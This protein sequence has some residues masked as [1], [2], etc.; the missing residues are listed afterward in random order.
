MGFLR[1]YV[2][3]K[4]TEREEKKRLH[5]EQ[6]EKFRREIIKT[7]ELLD[8]FT[9][10]QLNKFCRDM[11]GKSPE[12]EIRA[13]FEAEAEE[14][15]KRSIL[16]KGLHKIMS[17]KTE[18]A[19]RKTYYQF[20]EKCLREEQIKVS[21]IKDYAVKEKIV[22]PSYFGDESK[23]K[24]EFERLMNSIEDDFKPERIKEEKE[25]QAQ[26]VVFLKAKFA[27]MKVERE[28]QT[29]RGNE[30]D[31]LVENNYVFE[32]KVPKVRNDL[33]A[34]S[35]QVEEYLEEYPNLCVVIADVS[36][37]EK[38]NEDE[39]IDSNLTQ[40]IKEYADRYKMKYG[41]KTLIFQIQKRK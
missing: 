22:A 30:L 19:D 3:K 26:L 40:N 4:R 16:S 12:E 7:Y 15:A 36:K 25:F 1:N 38:I 14:D 18:T 24:K 35:A 41:V 5:E 34:L 6:L 28:Q 27:E 23:E 39:E 9:I 29:K 11:I 17:N 13:E 20:I 37:A 31:I 21:Q 32:L 33:R 10:P 2:E 8:K